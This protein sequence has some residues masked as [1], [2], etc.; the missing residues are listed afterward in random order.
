MSSVQQVMFS[1]F[2]MSNRVLWRIKKERKMFLAL[3]LMQTVASS[4]GFIKLGQQ[5][6][7]SPP[8][9]L[10]FMFQLGLEVL[11][12]WHSPRMKWVL[13]TLQ[14]P[15]LQ[16]LSP[17]PN[18]QER[19]TQ[20]ARE[21]LGAEPILNSVHSLFCSIIMTISSTLLAL[22]LMPLCLWLYSRAWIDTPLVQ[23]LPLGAVTLT[24]CS[25]L[26]PIG[27]GVFIRYKYNRV[28]DYIVKVRSLFLLCTLCIYRVLG[29]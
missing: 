26:I 28:A 19:V 23:L 25:T 14:A 20:R 4:V 12:S 2:T 6:S 24:L 21:T 17:L 5:P 11:F 8:P 22:V 10:G 9:I 18:V 13:P 3:R 1:S 16:S 27:L 29:L 7:D 15:D